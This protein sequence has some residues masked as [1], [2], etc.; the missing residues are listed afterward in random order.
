MLTDI[1]SAYEIRLGSQQSCGKREVAPSE[2]CGGAQ[3]VGDPQAVIEPDD[4]HSWYEQRYRLIGVAGQR[5][6]FVSYTEVNEETMR[7]ISA[8]DAE[9]HERRKYYEEQKW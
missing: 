7:L 9:P 4:E 2:F 8:R 5:L 1:S 6:L 3:G